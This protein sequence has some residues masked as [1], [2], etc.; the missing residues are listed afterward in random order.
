[1]HPIV[2]SELIDLLR[3]CTKYDNSKSTRWIH[4]MASN[5][6]KSLDG[7]YYWDYT[8]SLSN[9]LN[10]RETMM[11]SLRGTMKRFVYFMLTNAINMLK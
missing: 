2:G 9:V 1:M 8:N 7:S 4:A 10:T 6:P 11:N 3:K 5:H